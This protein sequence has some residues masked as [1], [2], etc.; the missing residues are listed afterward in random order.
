MVF[1]R[2]GLGVLLVVP[3]PLVCADALDLGTGVE[4]AQGE[5]QRRHGKPGPRPATGS[6]TSPRPEGPPALG[7]GG[8]V[9]ARRPEIF[10]CEV[11]DPQ[12][13]TSADT[14]PLEGIRDLFVFVTWPYVFGEHVQTVEF[15]LPDGHLY[16]RKETTFTLS[17]PKRRKL[18]PRRGL[19]MPTLTVSSAIDNRVQDKPGTSPEQLSTRGRQA[20]RMQR[21]PSERV[22]TEDRRAI[23][24]PPD[25]FLTV[26]R[27]VPTVITVLPV[28]GTFITQHRLAGTWTV[29]VLL[30]DKPL[31]SAQ[32]TLK[33]E[34]ED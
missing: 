16:Q 5:V 13:R 9:L 29:R 11:K 2:L 6:A 33:T 32:F 7:A 27:G 21:Q 3:P 8:I 15:T 12:C 28:A 22:S 24:L 26:S 4:G 19:P 34:G 20:A 1:L 23:R 30:D 18:N 14:F 31:L 25:R 10:F 17:P